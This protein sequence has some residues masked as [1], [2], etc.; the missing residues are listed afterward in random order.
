MGFPHSDRIQADSGHKALHDPRG[1]V[2]DHQNLT[3]MD[4]E[5]RKAMIVDHG[6]D[7]G[8]RW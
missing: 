2:Q 8:F 3:R 6:F 1:D 4:L 7:L 5:S